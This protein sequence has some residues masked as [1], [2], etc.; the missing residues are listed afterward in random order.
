ML[1]T[2]SALKTAFD[3]TFE[4]QGTKLDLARGR[5]R[6]IESRAV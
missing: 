1:R 6:Q 3:H 2:R 4:E 5:I